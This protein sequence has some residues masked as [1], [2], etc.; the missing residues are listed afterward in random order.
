MSHLLHCTLCLQVSRATPL[1]P[2]RSNGSDSPKFGAVDQ[3]L[4]VSWPA[5]GMAEEIWVL[6][7]LP[8][9]C[10]CILCLETKTGSTA[11]MRVCFPTPTDDV[12]FYGFKN[13]SCTITSVEIQVCHSSKNPVEIK[14]FPQC[15]LGCRKFLKLLIR[16]PKCVMYFTV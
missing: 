8:K 4:I 9:T 16:C 2:G 6:L 12:S 15:P 11:D 14:Y 10:S 3:V 1:C 13:G 5:W 7:L